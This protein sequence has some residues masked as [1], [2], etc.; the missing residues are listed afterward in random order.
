MKHFLTHMLPNLTCLVYSR[1]P[2]FITISPPWVPFITGPIKSLQDLRI[3]KAKVKND[4]QYE[5]RYGKNTEKK[6]DKDQSIECERKLLLK[7]I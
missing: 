2:A 5:L 3:L 7:G 1:D 6:A 4:K